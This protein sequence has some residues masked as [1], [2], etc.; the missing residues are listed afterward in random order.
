MN[1]ACYIIRAALQFINLIG[2]DLKMRLPR[3]HVVL[4][5]LKTINVTL[6]RVLNVQA[7]AEQTDAQATEPT[8]RRVNKEFETDSR[9]L[10]S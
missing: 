6:A 10:C 5:W 3:Q 2:G 4:K 9:A 8:G 1:K 7:C